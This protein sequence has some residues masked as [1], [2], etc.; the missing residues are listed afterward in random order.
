MHRLALRA[1]QLVVLWAVSTGIVWASV[2]MVGRRLKIADAASIALLGSLLSLGLM[3]VG[4]ILGVFLLWT[5]LIWFLCRLSLWRAAVSSALMQA[6]AFV[7]F[8]LV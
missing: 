3:L 2:R 6:L 4:G 7:M 5:G 1:I 8:H